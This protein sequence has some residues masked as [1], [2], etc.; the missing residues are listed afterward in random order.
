VAQELAVLLLL[1]LI[2]G[3]MHCLDVPSAERSGGVGIQQAVLLGK[4]LTLQ[5]A[6]PPCTA[7]MA[8]FSM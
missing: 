4:L 2:R 7:V 1:L 5:Q 3:Q 8:I 6:A